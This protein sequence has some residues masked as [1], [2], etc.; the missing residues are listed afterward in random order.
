MSHTNDCALVQYAD[1]DPSTLKTPLICDCGT[2]SDDGDDAEFNPRLRVALKPRVQVTETGVLLS[3]EQTRALQ[4]Y[5]N[6]ALA[7]RVAE[8]I[9]KSALDAFTALVIG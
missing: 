1:V 5:R 2:T 8:Q 4:A 7:L 3:P 6:A 9:A